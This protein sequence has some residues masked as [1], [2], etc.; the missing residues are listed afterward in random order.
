[1]VKPFEDAVFAMKPGEI[2]NLVESDFGFHI[3]QL[4]AV[5]GGDKKAFD[6]VRQEIETEVRRSL[7]QKRYAEAAEQFSETVY[8]Q[9]DSL[10][11]AIDKLKL[12]KRTATVARAPAPGASG[13]LASE[14]LL[15]AVFGNE[16]VNNKRNT[17]AVEVGPSQ[18]ASARIVKHEPARTLSLDEVKDRVRAAV[19][20]E[21]AA[22]L[23][24]K[25]G[26]ARLAALR[27]G[28]AT[29]PGTATVS[30]AQP[31]G[32]QREVIDA[33]LRADVTKGPADLGV[34]VGAQ[35]YVVTRVLKVLPR[36]P[37]PG[38]DAPLLAQIGQAW[39]TAEGDAYLAALKKRHKAEIVPAVVSQVAR[40]A[41]AP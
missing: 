20:A 40:S 3:I 32:L 15:T 6:Q 22:A 2:S 34:D 10:Q 28:E 5:R 39:A 36:E 35:G 37:L 38:G 13:P 33:V 31:Q 8:Q 27:K 24:R 29:L 1:M 25:D 16:A 19:V 9:Y 4:T 26:E 30:R 11:P 41:S 18:M 14:K 21:Q 12:E 23:A 7:A 17:D